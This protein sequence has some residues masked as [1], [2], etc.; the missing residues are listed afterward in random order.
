MRAILGA[1]LAFL[2]AP[3]LILVVYSFTSSKLVTVWGGFSTEWYGK[4][5]NNK[6]MMEA[7]NVSLK[8]ALTSAS[9]FCFAG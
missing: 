3:I 2:Y 7:A 6:A 9:S 8:V 1:G 4:L 5:L